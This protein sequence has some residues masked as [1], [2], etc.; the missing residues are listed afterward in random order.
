MMQGPSSQRSNPIALPIS[1]NV[2][3]VPSNACRPGKSSTPDATQDGLGDSPHGA[4]NG[5]FLLGRIGA[6]ICH[7]PGPKPDTAILLAIAS[8][9]AEGFW[10]AIARLNESS[11]CA[12]DDRATLLQ[13]KRQTIARVS[14]MLPHPLPSTA[15]GE[16][17]TAFWAGYCAY[18]N[19]ILKTHTERTAELAS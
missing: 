7:E 13:R 12:Q 19:E 5:M 11:R 10:L 16:A 9:P 3:A 18:W 2:R 4:S 8:R 15:S 1:S 6:I 14:R 17:Q